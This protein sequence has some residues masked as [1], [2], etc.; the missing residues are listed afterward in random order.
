MNHANKSS[1]Q[2]ATLMGSAWKI[3]HN[4]NYHQANVF[5]FR[6]LHGRSTVAEL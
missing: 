6:L 4:E 3:G 5:N 1:Q 2:S